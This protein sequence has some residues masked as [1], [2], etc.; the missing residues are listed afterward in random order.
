MPMLNL[1]KEQ[2]SHIT[3]LNDK[4]C[5]DA[6]QVQKEDRIKARF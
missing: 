6:I 3:A 1:L 2:L 5:L 4:K